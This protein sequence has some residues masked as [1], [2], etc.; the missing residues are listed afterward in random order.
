MQ[1]LS[2]KD[3]E[4]IAKRIVSAYIKLPSLQGQQSDKILP[5]LLVHDL[6]GLTTEFHALSRSGGIL[7]LTACGE[8]DVQIYDDPK[9]PEFFHLDGRTLLIDYVLIKED[10]NVDRY[11]F[12]LTHEACHQIFKM[13]FPREYAASVRLRQVHYCT[14]APAA[15]QDYWEAWRTNALASAVLMPEEMVRSNMAVFGLGEKMQM[16]IRVYAP[17]EYALF[18]DMSDHM[19]VSKQALAIRL[20]GMG[21]LE[22]DFLKDPYALV[23]I[24]PD[25]TEIKALRGD[26]ASC[27]KSI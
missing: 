21:L 5:E 9:H 18:S 15:G 8:V 11:H 2:R 10:A 17:G 24:Y 22:Q 26:G 6:L 12:T 20:K 4:G 13:L 25:D 27:Q 23:N 19:G 3:I 7:G 1:R 16:L 14:T